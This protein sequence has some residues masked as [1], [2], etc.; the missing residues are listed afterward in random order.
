[1]NSLYIDTR[2]NE[3]ISVRLESGKKKYSAE[4]KAN[5][6]KAQ[7]TLPLI[8]EVL[9]KANLK[10]HNVDEVIVETGP[11]SFTGLRVGIAIA[12]AFAFGTGIRINGKKLSEMAEPSY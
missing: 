2:S 1:M 11:G 3:K 9:K 7:A 8:Q 5:I 6:R 12:N 4:S 10:T